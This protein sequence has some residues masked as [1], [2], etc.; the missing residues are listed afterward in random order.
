[1]KHFYLLFDQNHQNW[2]AHQTKFNET[3][4]GQ[5]ETEQQAT[6]FSPPNTVY[7]GP[8]QRPPTQPDLSNYRAPTKAAG[9]FTFLELF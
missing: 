9:F 3:Q 7:V 5:Y 6:I 4:S 2:P 1:M 8:E